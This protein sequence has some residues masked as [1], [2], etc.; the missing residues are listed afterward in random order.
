MKKVL[1]VGQCGPD[2]SAIRHFLQT[3]FDV[4][5]QRTSLPADT[6][7]ALRRQPF[8]LV[9]IN[10]KLDEDYSDG[11]EI[12]KAIK[13]DPDIGQTP[14]MLV[15]NYA[16]HQAE[17]VAAGGEQGFG[18]NDLRHAKTAELLKPFLG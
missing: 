12:L 8:D 17:S 14:V 6:L 3:H 5:I 11:L 18:K 7:A 9:L 13:Q 1:D 16:E 10:R 2:H 4:E 15:T